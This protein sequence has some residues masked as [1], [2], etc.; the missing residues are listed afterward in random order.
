[1]GWMVGYIDMTYAIYEFISHVNFLNFF[2]LIRKIIK[3][4]KHD[5]LML[6]TVFPRSL[7]PFWIVRIL[8]K[9]G[10]DLWDIQ[11]MDRIRE[12]CT[13]TKWPKISYVM[14]WLGCNRMD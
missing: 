12:E 4:R 8:Y 3:H 10:Q 7:H 2:A 11:Y 13:A 6:H 9:I 5:K 14:Y 1:M